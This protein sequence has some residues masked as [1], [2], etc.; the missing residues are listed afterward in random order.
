VIN[1]LKRHLSISATKISL[2]GLLFSVFFLFPSI[3]YA[4]TQAVSGKAKALNTTSNYLDFTNYN[5]NVTIDNT[6]GNFSGYAF[7]EDVGWAA[8]GTTDN[9]SGPVNV[10]LT[11]GAVTGK[12][13]I[14]GTTN[15][16]IDFT[17][18][19]SNVTLTLSS[20]VFSGFAFSE[21][22]GW[23]DFSDTG[24]ST[25]AIVPTPT[26]TPTT[27]TSDTSSTSGSGTSSPSAPGCGEVAPS[28]A[29]W[30]YGA[31]TQNSTSILLYFTDAGDPVDSYALEFGTEPGNYQWGATNIGGKGMRTYLVQ[32][33]QPNKTYYFRVRGGNGCA[34]GAWSNELSAKTK[35]LVGFNQLQTTGFELETTPVIPEEVMEEVEEQESSEVVD[36]EDSE[37]EITEDVEEVEEGYKVNVKVT[38]DSNKPV[39][40]AKVTMHSKVQE[41][42]TDENGIARFENVEPGDHRVLIAYSGFEGEQAINLTGDVKEFNLNVTVKPT[43]VFLAPPVIGFMIAAGVVILIM[44]GVII[45]LMKKKA[46]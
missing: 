16:F 29:P 4:A 19:S 18:Y 21:A 10:N 22:G 37:E 45:R 17:N 5:S 2:I 12:A 20:G 28:S 39:K 3:T 23:L 14:L 6:T 26:P 1:I 41:T 36:E 35:G 32:S 43:N 11:T 7:L 31:I 8:F 25:A 30:L 42:T 46:V 38:D 24:V 40:G 34:T 15:S 13:Q 44:G 9:A 33:L 27:T